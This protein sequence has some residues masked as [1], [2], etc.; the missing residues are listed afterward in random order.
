M[1]AVV[2]APT[3]VSDPGEPPRKTR[4]TL[5]RRIWLVVR[6]VVVVALGYLAVEVIVSNSAELTGAAEYLES[7]NWAWI[8]AAA[9]AEAVSYVAFTQLQRV[10]L[11]SG[12]LR[13]GFGPMTAITLAGN[14]INSTLPGGGAFATVF[15]YRQFRRRGADEALTT[16]TLVAFTALTAVTLALLA[17]AGLL[18]AGGGGPVAG[19]WPLIPVLMALPILGVVVLARPRVLLVVCVAPLRWVRR[20]TGFPRADPKLI[21][22]SLVERLQTVTPR[23]HEWT[24]GLVWASANWLTDCLCLVL[25]FEAV[26][27]HVPWR[28]LLVAYGAAQVASNLPFTPGGL[29]VVEGSLT[30]ALV[31]YG[32][33]TAG[34]VAAVLLYRI[35]SFWLLLPIGWV[36]WFGL[37]IDARRHPLRP[38]IV[39]DVELEHLEPTGR[40]AIS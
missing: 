20:V 6:I 32:G 37:A 3:V 40:E 33:S 29:G 34:S 19:L 11:A 38:G 24:L 16:W 28:G 22:T 12:G 10:L 26:G 14:A 30:I 23:F 15:A 35:L 36:A 9:G 21:L 8:L 13:T 17:V 31:A 18:I 7:A 25:A 1:V 5:G 4:S 27:A 39:A 2:G